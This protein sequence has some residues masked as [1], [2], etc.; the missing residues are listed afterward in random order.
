MA[1]IRMKFIK[2][3]RAELEDLQEDI[4]LVEQKASERLAL[5]EITE[6]V[7][8]ENK[9]LL[10]LESE[11]IKKLLETI[12]SIDIALYK[13]VDE[14]AIGLDGRVHDVVRE[15]EDPEAVYRF[16]LRKL[17]KVRKYVESGE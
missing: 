2:V 7:Y 17:M 10:H 4:A 1:D 11:S 3:L 9:G 8:R 14:L 15:H 6:Y 5:S 12:D 13:N 16:F